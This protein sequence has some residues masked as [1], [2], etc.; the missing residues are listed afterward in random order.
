MASAPD[1][2]RVEQVQFLFR[3]GDRAALK[4]EVYKTDPYDDVY[5]GIGY[6]QLTKIGMQRMYRLGQMLRKRYADFLG[7]DPETGEFYAR[8]TESER[9]RVSL[10][11]VLAGL[12]PPRQKT[13]WHDELDWVPM[14]V[15]YVHHSTDILM[16]VVQ[17]ANYRKLLREVFESTDFRK[18]FDKYKDF[19]ARYTEATHMTCRRPLS[20]ILITSNL[21]CAQALGLPRPDWC[22]DEDF[23]TLEEIMGKYYDSMV[24]TDTMKKL[25]TGPFLEE[26]LKNIQRPQDGRVKMYLY[27]AHEFNL[28]CFLRAHRPTNGPML[29]EFGSC[30]AIEKLRGKD[31]RVYIRILYWDGG[32]PAEPEQMYPLKFGDSNRMEHLLEDYLEMVRDILPDDESKKLMPKYYQKQP[33]SDTDNSTDFAILIAG[34]DLLAVKNYDG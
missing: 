3:H 1:E 18:Q 4:W 26:A 16:S 20:P 9:T 15:H 22:S 10:Q 12:I 25:S 8:S 28:G 19:Y 27:S 14:P 6:G 30:I 7:D 33:A 34:P 2:F 31:D 13:R 5:R 11:L 32:S 24:T 23:A 17:E 29:P 21:K